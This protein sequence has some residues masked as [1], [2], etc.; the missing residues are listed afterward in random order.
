MFSFGVAVLIASS[1]CSVKIDSPL[2]SRSCDCFAFSESDF[3]SSSERHWLRV[4]CGASSTA[5]SPRSNRI[6]PARE[7]LDARMVKLEALIRTE[8]HSKAI[9]RSHK[10]RF[11]QHFLALHTIDVRKTDSTT[12]IP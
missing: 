7:A 3:L 10:Q 8:P 11:C 5:T 2:Y 1:S 4:G 12:A 6:A 9:E